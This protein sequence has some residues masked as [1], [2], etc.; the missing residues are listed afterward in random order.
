MNNREKLV[1][2]GYQDSIVYQNPSFDS[3]IIGVDEIS[4]G[5]IYDYDLMIADMME[6]DHITAEQ[7]IQFIDY[8]TIKATPYMPEPRPIILRRFEEE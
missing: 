3:A 7:A 2:F 4:G 5:V 1:E 6:K 8:N